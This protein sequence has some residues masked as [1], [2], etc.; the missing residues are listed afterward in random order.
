MGE[1]NNYA[2]LRY[3]NDTT[4]KPNI[5]QRDLADKIGIAFS[6]ISKLEREGCDTATVSTIKAYKNYFSEEQNEDICYEYFMEETATKNKKYYELGKLFP[7]DDTFY[8]NLSQLL[9]LDSG[10]HMIEL[11]LSALLSNPH[12][13]FN[14]LVTIYNS[15]YQI[16]DIRQNK[17]LSATEKTRM[18]KIQEYV[19]SQTTIEY[20]E[21]IL[22]PVLH[23]AFEETNDYKAEEAIITQQELDELNSND[24]V[25]PVSA[26]VNIIEVKQI[27]K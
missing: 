9:E 20:L 21:N 7:F 27:E 6:T 26:I 11:M 16:N 25:S 18:L 5:S 24:T 23:R 22:I 19:F 17:E 8:K 12:E 14:A 10:N 4:W 13:L 3:D 2:K 1:R 15:L